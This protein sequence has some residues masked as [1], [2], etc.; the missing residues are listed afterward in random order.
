[1]LT[2]SWPGRVYWYARRADGTFARGRSLRHSDGAEIDVDRSSAPFA[3]D[4]DGD[5]DRDLLVGNIGGAIVLLPN[6]FGPYNTFSPGPNSTC[7]E[8]IPAKCS[9]FRR[10]N[11][12]F[13][14]L[15]LQSTAY[16][17]VQ[18]VD[19]AVGHLLVLLI[20]P[21]TFHGL[22]QHVWDVL[23]KLVNSDDA[24]PQVRPINLHH[25][26]ATV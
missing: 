13:G 1:M 21:K 17:L 7:P 25:A 26:H 2:G 12:M 16:H 20:L 22:F 9:I 10:T 8:A 18:V 15:S 23:G 3:A 14:T 6:S 11:R 5:G 4:W 19:R 24:V